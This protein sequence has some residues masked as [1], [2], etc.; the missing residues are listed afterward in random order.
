MTLEED[1]RKSQGAYEKCSRRLLTAINSKYKD[2][3]C[4][5]RPPANI[6]LQILKE[7]MILTHKDVKRC[8]RVPYKSKEQGL[9]PDMILSPAL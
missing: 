7:K 1:I 3:K 6:V 5:R 4:L 2:P 8:F 9:F